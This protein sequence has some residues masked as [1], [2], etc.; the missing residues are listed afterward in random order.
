MQ[1]QVEHVLEKLEHLSP[2]RLAEVEDFI[3]FLSQRDQD[4]RLRR[5]Y[6]QASEAV[7]NKVWDNDD[8]AIYDSQ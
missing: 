3:D 6:V 1:P 8:D 2:D 7:F 5:D 4:K